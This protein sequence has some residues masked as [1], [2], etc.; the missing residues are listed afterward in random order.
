MTITKTLPTQEE[1][2]HLYN[3]AGWSAYTKDMP[4]LMAALGHSQ[5]VICAREDGQLVGLVRSVGDGHTILYVQ[6]IL[7]LKSHQQQG[8]GRLLLTALLDKYPQVRQTVLITDKSAATDAFYRKLGFVL[9]EEHNI[10]CYT[11]MRK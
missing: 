3:D 5:D 8:V 10:G 7:V 6:D 11:Y 4:R 2:R 9:S 1:T